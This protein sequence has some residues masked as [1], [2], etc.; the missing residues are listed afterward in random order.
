MPG[1]EEYSENVFKYLKALCELFLSKTIFFFYFYLIKNNILGISQEYSLLLGQLYKK[2]SISFS[3]SHKKFILLHPT[4]NIMKILTYAF[5][6]V[7]Y[8]TGFIFID[9]D[10]D[11]LDD[12]QSQLRL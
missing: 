4:N 1:H 10:N 9:P 3:E 12:Q 11:N 2:N 8:S 7:L 6:V 5:G